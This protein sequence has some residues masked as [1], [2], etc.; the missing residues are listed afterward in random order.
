MHDGGTRDVTLVLRVW[1]ESH[2]PQIRARLVCLPLDLETTA[3]GSA[4]I[5]AAVDAALQAFAEQR[6]PD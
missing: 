1:R 5:L 6:E 3:A 2:D 4:A